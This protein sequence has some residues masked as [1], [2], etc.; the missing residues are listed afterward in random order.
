MNILVSS[1][2]LKYQARGAVTPLNFIW[3]II[4]LFCDYFCLRRLF[5]IL[6]IV[7]ATNLV[8]LVT[9]LHSDFF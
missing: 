9:V 6:E 2:I 5:V 4:F 1:A 3:T 8:W 7:S